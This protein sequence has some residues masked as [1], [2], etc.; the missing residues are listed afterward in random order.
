MCQRGKRLTPTLA[1]GATATAEGRLM[2]GGPSPVEGKRIA[3]KV[4][5][6]FGGGTAYRNWSC[7][8]GRATS[9]A[10]ACVSTHAHLGCQPTVA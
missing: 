9:R 6:Q 8:T 10:P 2:K 1:L 4:P 3:R 7:Q 5:R